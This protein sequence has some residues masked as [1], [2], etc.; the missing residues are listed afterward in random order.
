[1][2]DPSVQVTRAPSRVQIS[3][4]FYQ[5]K[6]RFY[7]RKTQY[8][9]DAT[10]NPLPGTLRFAVGA[11]A[12]RRV[13]SPLS[14][15][16]LSPTSGSGLQSHVLRPWSC[17]VSCML[18]SVAW[19]TRLSADFQVCGHKRTLMSMSTCNIWTLVAA[20]WLWSSL[21][22]LRFAARPWPIDR[23]STASRRWMSP[24]TCNLQIT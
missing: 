18:S 24:T 21:E 3:C 22:P 9:H 6:A 11:K 16:P 1:M 4:C 14:P 13:S 15:P 12:G 20:R 19:P 8:A 5:V 2:T 7:H 23:L 10:T 17:F